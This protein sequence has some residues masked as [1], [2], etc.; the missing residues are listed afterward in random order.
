MV[1]T[2]KSKRKQKLPRGCTQED[3]D[4][5]RDYFSA[6]VQTPIDPDQVKKVGQE[7]LRQHVN[8]ALILK[9][10]KQDYKCGMNMQQLKEGLEAG[11]EAAEGQEPTPAPKATEKRARF[12]NSIPA[13]IR[14]LNP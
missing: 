13:Q 11:P 1:G 3:L 5:V 7:A 14:S 9:V 12:P 8:S 2:S 10:M 6:N 4:K